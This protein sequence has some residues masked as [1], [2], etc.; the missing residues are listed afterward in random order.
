MQLHKLACSY[1]SLHAVTKACMQLYKLACRSMR[2]PA[3]CI[4]VLGQMVKFDR[5]P[6][7]EYIQIFKIHRI[8]MAEHLS[9][10]SLY[11][12][13]GG[14]R[15]KCPQWSHGLTQSDS[16]PNPR[17]EGQRRPGLKWRCCRTGGSRG[18]GCGAAGRSC[19]R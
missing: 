15:K 2:L 6:N 19:T 11:L 3:A 1:I 8:M 5:L 12:Q 17:G 4:L 9:C 13:G 7:T 10:S 18:R 14:G 16:S